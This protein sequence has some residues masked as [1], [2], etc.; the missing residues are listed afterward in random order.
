M[1]LEG[2]SSK[3]QMCSSLPCL[4]RGN[5][6]EVVQWPL[7]ERLVAAVI[8]WHEYIYIFFLRD[9]ILKKTLFE[10]LQYLKQET[11]RILRTR[12]KQTFLWAPFNS[13]YLPILC[14]QLSCILLINIT[15]IKYT[16]IYAFTDKSVYLIAWN[17]RYNRIAG[18]YKCV[19]FRQQNKW[20]PSKVFTFLFRSY[21]RF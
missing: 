9:F 15:I 1:I 17:C 11:T 6:E 10:K 4:I 21:A 8:M 5:E 12:A 18:R 7:T 20:Y 16:T 14:L 3:R 19:P 13:S 2:P